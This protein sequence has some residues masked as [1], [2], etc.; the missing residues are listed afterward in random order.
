MKKLS[1]LIGL[2]LLSSCALIG[3]KKDPDTKPNLTA[4]DFENMA[5]Q[6]N[7]IFN[8]G[9]PYPDTLNSGNSHPPIKV[10]PLNK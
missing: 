8:N 4:K 7:V 9:F 5:N 2:T 1:Y 6:G 10:A 3:C